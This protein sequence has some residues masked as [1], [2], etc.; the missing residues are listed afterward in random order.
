MKKILLYVTLLT[1]SSFSYAGDEAMITSYAAR[2]SANDKVNSEGKHLKSVADIIRQD[3]ANFHKFGTSD[4]EDQADDFF[5]DEKN[6]ERIPVML[7]K[8]HIDKKT[9]NAILNDS[10]LVVIN[11]Y[12]N[13]LDVYLQ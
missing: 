7:K 10:P 12:S 4:A 13:H 1:L 8:G 6:R 9:Q 2:I 5:D 3:R 11:V